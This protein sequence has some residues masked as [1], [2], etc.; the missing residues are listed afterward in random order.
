MERQFLHP[1]GDKGHD[2]VVRRSGRSSWWINVRPWDRRQG[3][4]ATWR[5]WSGKG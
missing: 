2:D 4:A 1:V 3:R 5:W